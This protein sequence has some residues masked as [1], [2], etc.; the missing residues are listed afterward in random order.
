MDFVLNRLGTPR[1]FSR[2]YTTS[3]LSV[4]LVIVL[5]STSLTV[6]I[7]FLPLY[8]LSLPLTSFP[9][10]YLFHLPSALLSLSLALSSLYR[11]LTRFLTP[12]LDMSEI[13]DLVK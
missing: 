6:S 3:I 13:F 4:F 7:S 9:R 12:S 5:L 8:P 2:P 10:Q 1:P 11:S